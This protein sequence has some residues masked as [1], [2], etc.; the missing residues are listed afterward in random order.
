[1]LHLGE[2]RPGAAGMTGQGKCPNRKILLSSV[3]SQCMSRHKCAPGW[4]SCH[5]TLAK[6]FTANSFCALLLYLFLCPCSS[7]VSLAPF[8]YNITS[9]QVH[10]LFMANP[11]TSPGSNQDVG[12]PQ[13][14][15]STNENQISMQHEWQG[16][17]KCQWTHDPKPSYHRIKI[18]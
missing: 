18:R 17:E 6:D 10:M 8:A 11:G 9:E 7:L 14:I 2:Q 13:E 5:F 1:M 4:E 15:I 12:G 16:G 3:K